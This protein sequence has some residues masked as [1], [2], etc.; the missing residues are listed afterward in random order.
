MKTNTLIVFLVIAVLAVGG[1]FAYKNLNGQKDSFSNQTSGET[2]TSLDEGLSRE[3][4]DLVNRKHPVLENLASDTI[5]VK[6]VS[7]ANVKSKNLTEAE[8]ADLDQKWTKSIANDPWISGFLT[9]QVAGSLSSFQEK[10]PGFVEIFVTDGRGL[11]VGQTNKTSDYYQ[12]DEDWWVQAFNNGAGKTY[13]G[14]LEYDESAKSESIPIYAPVKDENGK[15]I[16]VM[17]AVLSITAL[18]QEL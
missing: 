16:G 7:E 2:V 6:A 9:N 1:F 5:L 4:E 10:N 13:H 12:A 3:V 17:K 15:A 8:I 18:R 11:N 14:M